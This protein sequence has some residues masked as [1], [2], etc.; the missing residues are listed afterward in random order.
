MSA[1]WA[2]ELGQQT[3][4]PPLGAKARVWSRMQRRAKRRG[5]ALWAM[6]PVTAVVVAL[7]VVGTQR[8]LE[9]KPLQTW[10]GPG[11]LAAAKGTVEWRDEGVV[12]LREGTLAVSVW[13]KKP[14][15][16]KAAGHTIV[17]ESAS[18]VITVAG[19][20]FTV[21]PLQG[22][23]LV[24]EVVMQATPT[25]RSQAGP[26]AQTLEAR[27]PPEAEVNR[28][29]RFAEAAV[30]EGKPVEALMA[31]ERAS[32][33]SSASAEVALFR[34]GELQLRVLHNPAAAVATFD[35]GDAR[36]P[37]G[38]LST[39]RALSALEATTTLKDWVEVARRSS[40]FLEA[41]G[42]SERADDVR[43]LRSSALFS[44]GLRQEACSEL[45]AIDPPEWRRVCKR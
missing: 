36:F 1:P 20:A 2:R 37:N 16:V 35:S 24:D 11:H 17:V 44:M 33:Q 45:K 21:A 32:K 22:S 27:E 10:Q 19:D 15:R 31:L 43:K 14:V 12:E 6:V 5:L 7:V 3:A 13:R 18:V 28:A 9:P 26:L 29:L 8:A 25:S 30:A 38:S 41:H 42:Q 4:S 40:D 23:V 39:E 34:K